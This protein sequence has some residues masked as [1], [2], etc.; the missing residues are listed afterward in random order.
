MAILHMAILHMAI[1]HMA[2]LHM[3]IFSNCI[4][5]LHHLWITLSQDWFLDTQSNHL[6]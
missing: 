4:F 5:K 1:L 6:K 2:I 3:A